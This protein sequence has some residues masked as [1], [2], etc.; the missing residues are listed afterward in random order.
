LFF[1]GSSA[2]HE[3]HTNFVAAD[4]MI[5]QYG[6]ATDGAHLENDMHMNELKFG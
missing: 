1:P 6:H 4:T 2:K 3:S 5:S